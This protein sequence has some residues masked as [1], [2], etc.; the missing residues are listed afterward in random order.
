MKK[1]IT[2]FVAILMLISGGNVTTVRATGL[3]INSKNF[4]D[5]SFRDYVKTIYDLDKNDYL[6]KTEISKAKIMNFTHLDVKTLKGIQYLENLEK[7]EISTN[8]VFDGFNNLTEIDL[9]KNLNLKDIRLQSCSI[10]KL[11]LSK[12]TKL[13][14]L[15]L[16]N[17]EITSLNLTKNTKLR[18]LNMYDGFNLKSVDLS[19]NILLQ[20]LRVYECDKLGSLDLRKNIL[21]QVLSVDRCDKLGSLDLRKNKELE[22]LSILFND[23]MNVNVNNEQ[24]KKLEISDRKIVDLDKMINITTLSIKDDSLVNLN[25]SKNTKLKDLTISY[26]ENLK[27]LDITKNT[28]LEKLSIHGFGMTSLNLT[29]NTKL[30]SLNMYEGFNL[31]SID[32]SKNILLQDLSVVDCD[33]L[34]SLDLRKNKELEELSILSNDTINVNVNNKQIKKL[35]IDDIKLVDLNKMVNVTTLSIRDECSVNLNLSKNTKLKDL[36]ISWAENLKTLDITKNTNLEEL[37]LGYCGLKS[38]DLSKNVKLK[39]IEIIGCNKLSDLDFSKNIYLEDIKLS[40]NQSLKS[41]NISQN[42]LINSWENYGNDKLKTWYVYTPNVK[43]VINGNKATLKWEKCKYVDHFQIYKASTKNGTYKKVA[44]TTGTSKTFERNA[45]N[46]YKVRIV[47]FQP[48]GYVGVKTYGKFSNIVKVPKLSKPSQPT[49]NSNPTYTSTQYT[50]KWSKCSNV[51]G[52]QI[53]RSTK[54]DS[55]YK[56]VATTTGTSKSFKITNK[57]VYYYKVR[58]YRK[59]GNENVY[60]KFSKPILVL[61]Y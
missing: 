34:G 56:K 51:D 54:P 10:K 41:I 36:A 13:E 31:K 8:F 23:T 4:P 45:D 55:S 24:I 58:S 15:S 19:K 46:Y 50:I 20:D 17:F 27:T 6:S 16:E 22:E 14:K 7:L 3:K 26:A 42:K 37:L 52:Y 18:S 29:K 48:S 60:S 59:N 12:N 1:I 30:R 25:L 39:E 5:N 40:Y 11:D 38:L 47:Y 49:I 32:L 44:S 57:G 21:L 61:N 35:A 53:Y 9:S 43:T 33:K 2:A 28:K